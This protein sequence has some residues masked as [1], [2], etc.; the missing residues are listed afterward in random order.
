M[1]D[2][3]RKAATGSLS[4]DKRRSWTA[5][6]EGEGEG[7]DQGPPHAG[8]R[9]ELAQPGSTTRGGE[10]GGSPA[11]EPQGRTGARGEGRQPR[12]AVEEKP[13]RGALFCLSLA[14]QARGETTGSSGRKAGAGH[15]KGTAGRTQPSWWGAGFLGSCPAP[16]IQRFA[17][18][19]E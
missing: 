10:G 4:Q 12:E 3:R 14:G 17:E 11:E 2:M 6:W 13:R 19:N 9:P 8:Q 7:R 18:M 16:S 15:R 1:E 5:N